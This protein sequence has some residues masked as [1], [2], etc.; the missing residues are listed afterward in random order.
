M[1]TFESLI[2]CKRNS[3]L[4]SKLLFLS[5][6][7]TYANQKEKPRPLVGCKQANH[8]QHIVKATVG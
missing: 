6:Q 2:I 7:L 5:K 8:E 3:K 4:L 1:I